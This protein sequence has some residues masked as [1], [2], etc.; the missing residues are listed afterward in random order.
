MSR[1]AFFFVAL[2][3]VVLI[4]GVVFF[5]GSQLGAPA[6][7]LALAAFGFANILILDKIKPAPQTPSEKEADARAWDAFYQKLFLRALP[8]AV[9]VWI[10]YKVAES[11]G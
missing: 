7:F 2:S 11:L 9:A 6:A 10:L 1:D 4:Y 8:S 5:V 3:L